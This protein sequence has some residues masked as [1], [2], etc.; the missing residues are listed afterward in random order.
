MSKVYLYSRVSTNQQTLEQQERTVYE[1]L[2]LHN[3]H[4]DEVVSDC[5]ISGGV[6]YA[7]RALGK[8]LLPKMNAGDMLIV[9]EISRLGRSMFDLSKLIHTELKPRK[10]RLVVCNMSID[11]RCDRLTAIDEL[12]LN[13]FSFAA[14]LEKQLISE[15]TLSALEV[16]RK[17]GVKFGA[18][19]ELYKARRARKTRETIKIESMKHGETKRMRFQESKNVVAF[20]KVL[21]R[22]QPEHCENENPSKWE[23]AGINT[24]CGRREQILTMMRDFK[25]MDSENKLFRNWNFEDIND[26]R[27]Q[28]KLCAFI[29]N[30]RNSFT[31]SN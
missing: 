6:S 3:M 16:K 1:W 24:K 31:S 15:R 13:N 21:K 28:M 27:L 30:V 29:Q 2:K 20:L 10:L 26:R 9:S 19:S 5:G 8:V 12:I 17:Q 4:V 22:V 23:W 25:E 18:A 11:L 7:D 14:Q